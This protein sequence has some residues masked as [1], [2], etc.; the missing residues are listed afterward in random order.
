M[1]N[2]AIHVMGSSE[3]W[4]CDLLRAVACADIFFKQKIADIIYIYMYRKM[5]VYIY[6]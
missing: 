3:L 2:V 1:I 5:N 6:I 4:S